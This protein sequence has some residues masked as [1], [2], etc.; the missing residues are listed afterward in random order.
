MAPKRVWEGDTLSRRIVSV[1]ERLL[2]LRLVVLDLE[3]DAQNRFEEAL[4]SLEQV[5]L[6]IQPDD[7]EGRLL[8]EMRS[9][10]ERR[11][12]SMSQ[13]ARELEISRQSLHAIFTGKSHLGPKMVGRLTEWLSHS[14]AMRH[15]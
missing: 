8:D 5:F 10:I 11:Q 2:R 15:P 13:V 4:S 14:R 7:P 6:E 9:E 3:E 1:S 12:V